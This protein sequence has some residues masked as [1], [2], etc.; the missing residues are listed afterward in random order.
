MLCRLHKHVGNTTSKILVVGMFPPL[1]CIIKP[2]SE[3]QY[4][5][6]IHSTFHK[7]WFTRISSW[8]NYFIICFKQLYLCQLGLSVASAIFSPYLIFI[9]HV[10]INRIF[11]RL[12]LWDHK[13]FVQWF[14]VCLM[15]QKALKEHGT[16]IW[17]QMA[18]KCNLLRDVFSQLCSYLANEL[19]DAGWQNVSIHRYNLNHRCLISLMH[20]RGTR[21]LSVGIEGYS[22]T[23]TKWPTV[24]RILFR[25][26]FLEFNKI[27]YFD[28]NVTDIC[29]LGANWL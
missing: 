13:P 6:A 28:Q 22:Y 23:E 12:R 29:S 7:H 26:H 1:S 25:V 4:T 3:Q 27:L 8:M 20:C 5:H 18:F 14:L 24:C 21:D 9:F 10:R 19:L 11:A 17:W 2:S 16:C 15:P